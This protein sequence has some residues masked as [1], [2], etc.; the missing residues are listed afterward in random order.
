[1][2]DMTWSEEVAA[3]PTI[4]LREYYAGLAMQGMLINTVEFGSLSTEAIASE[5]VLAADAI[6]AALKEAQECVEK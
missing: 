5:A 6:I 4:T 3:T 1:M 2:S